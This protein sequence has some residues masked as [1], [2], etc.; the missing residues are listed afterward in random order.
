MRHTRGT[1]RR[2]LDTNPRAV[3]R[4]IIRL[5]SFQTADERGD[6]RT[7]WLNGQG[8]SVATVK[9]GTQLARKILAGR[10]LTRE[11][12]WD[13]AGI[14]RLHAGQLAEFANW[15]AEHGEVHTQGELERMLRAA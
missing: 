15:R 11:E 9:R 7:R 10:G 6:T 4:G 12:Y 3:E 14:C 13:A 5:F 1:I 8:F 2:L